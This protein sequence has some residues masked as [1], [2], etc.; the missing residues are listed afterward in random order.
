METLETKATVASRQPQLQ[1]TQLNYDE[2]NYFPPNILIV[3]P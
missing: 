2:K 3:V 1:K